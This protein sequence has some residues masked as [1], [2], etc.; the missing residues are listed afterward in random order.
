MR[1]LTEVFIF[2][3]NGSVWGA[4]MPRT[5]PS[6]TVLLLSASKSLQ[7]AAVALKS[8][9]PLKS[10]PAPLLMT[11]AEYLCGVISSTLIL[12]GT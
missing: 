3:E 8:V 9:N 11:P 12:T 5:I 7:E 10:S 1:E 6:E 2:L 4:E